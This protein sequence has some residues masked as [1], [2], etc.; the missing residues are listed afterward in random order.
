MLFN[1]LL[2]SRTKKDWGG[3]VGRARCMA[4]GFCTTMDADTELQ[5]W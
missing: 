3:N 2:Q 1:A 4:H 5:G